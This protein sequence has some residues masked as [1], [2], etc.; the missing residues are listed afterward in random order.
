MTFS[1]LQNVIA[2][3]SPVTHFNIKEGAAKVWPARNDSQEGNFGLLHRHAALLVI[4]RDDVLKADMR[5][6]RLESLTLKR[7]AAFFPIV[8]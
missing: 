1:W 7:E 2:T 4:R 5:T 8:L 6:M 3:P